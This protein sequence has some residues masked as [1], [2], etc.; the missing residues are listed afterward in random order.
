MLNP[1][2][3]ADVARASTLRLRHRRRQKFTARFYFSLAAGCLPVFVDYWTRNLTSPSS[4]SHTRR[5]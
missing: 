4:R 2:E 1:A 5:F 3:A